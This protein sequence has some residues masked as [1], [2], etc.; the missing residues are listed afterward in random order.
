MTCLC[1]GTLDDNAVFVVNRNNQNPLEVYRVDLG[2]GK[3]TLWKD[4][5][6]SDPAGIAG[7]GFLVMT[8]DGKTYALYFSP[9]P[10]RSLSCTR[11]TIID[12]TT[13]R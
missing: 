1:N 2:N 6:P 10:I 3:R 12:L 13:P 7:R 11:L 9:C 8:P 4:I 5:T